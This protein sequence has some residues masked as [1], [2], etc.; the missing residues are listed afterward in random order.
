MVLPPSTGKVIP[1]IQSDSSPARNNA[2]LAT[3]RAVPTRGE[4]ARI[5]LRPALGRDL[6]IADF[7][8]DIAGGDG[9]APDV[10]VGVVDRDGSGQ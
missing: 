3:S 1:V 6:A 2:A 4:V 8:E 7:V 10:L 5:E 9:V